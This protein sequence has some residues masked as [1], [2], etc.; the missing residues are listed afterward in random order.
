MYLRKIWLTILLICC[1][2]F[3]FAGCKENRV[4]ESITL[5]GYSA[6]YP[7]NFGIGKFSYKDKTVVITYDNGDT[8]E[9]ALTEDMIS[10]TDKLK[11]YQDGKNEIA[12]TYQSV[13]TSIQIN[14]FRNQFSNTVALHDFTATYTGE[15]FTVEVEGDIP[16]SAK[17]LYPQGNTFTNAGTYDMTAILQC[18]GYE[19]KVLSARVVIE[20]ATYDVTGA[21]LYDE[22]VTYNKD[23]HKLVLK[24][25]KIE[26][27]GTV[28]YSPVVLP[29]GVRE[30]YSIIKIKDGD[31]KDIAL[32]K[33]QVVSDNSAK[34]AGVYVVR[35]HL[36][37]DASNYNAIPDKEALLTI[38]RASYDLSKVEFLNGTYTYSGKAYAVSIAENSKLPS[39]VEVAYQI[40]QLK[41]GAG[42]V[43][44]DE[45]KDGN[46]AINTGEYKVRAIFSVNGEN[47]KNYQT[48]PLYLEAK[49]TIQRASYDEELQDVGLDTQ[50]FVFEENKRYEIPFDCELPQ[51]VSP[52]FTVT[53]KNG[54]PIDVIWDETTQ[55]YSFTV[56]EPGEYTCIVTF[57]HTNEHYKE[58]TVSVTTWFIIN[59]NE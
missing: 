33:Q 9:L 53:D 3:I 47:A 51:G 40:K 29:Q 17:I 37:G 19:T 32:D 2:L 28:V 36:K 12:I 46:T 16:G 49:L 23:S 27:N 7:L 10:E 55:K 31:G 24:G 26:T 11:F 45:Y 1:S 57:T 35:A 44:T 54:D 38:E 56:K 30:S 20:K 41:N 58:I 6:E 5:K 39:D 21:Q 4:A 59:N 52:Q 42:Q 25:K 50:R 22:T 14:V 43:V 8:E 13:T 18:D 48:A 34:N 15:T